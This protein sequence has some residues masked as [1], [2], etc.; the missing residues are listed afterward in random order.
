MHFSP[1]FYFYAATG[2]AS[3]WLFLSLCHCITAGGKA[4][5]EHG[6]LGQYIQLRIDPDSVS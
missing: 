4:T 5:R 3:L 2:C 6:R 1:Y